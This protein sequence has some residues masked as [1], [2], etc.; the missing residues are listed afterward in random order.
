MNSSQGELFMIKDKRSDSVCF[1]RSQICSQ[2][3]ARISKT[4]HWKDRGQY[5]GQLFGNF[6]SLLLV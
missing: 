2:I 1:I 5:T 6:F 3:L 4:K